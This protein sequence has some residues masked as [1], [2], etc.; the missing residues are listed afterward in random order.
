MFH[1]AKDKEQNKNPLYLYK[2]L[3]ENDP[4][5]FPFY[6]IA[7]LSLVLMVLVAL[8]GRGQ[9]FLGIIIWDNSDTFMDYFNSV[10]DVITRTPYE[11]G[12]IYPPLANLVY[13]IFGHLSS[14]SS[15]CLVPDV[16]T[17][18]EMR[19]YQDYMLPFILY[20]MLTVFGVLVCCMAMKRGSERERLAFTFLILFSAPMI[21]GFERANI[22]V[23]ALIFTMIFF[24]WKDS[25]NKVLR[26]IAL[27]S[28]AMAAALKIYPAIFG[29]LVLRE[30]RFKETSRLI[31]YGLFFLFVPFVFF[32]GFDHITMWIH[33]ISQMSS[34]VAE[35]YYSYKLNFSNTF[36]WL[37]NGAFPGLASTIFTLTALFFGIAGCFL[38]RE[39][40]KRILMATLLLIGVPQI[41]YIYVAI[42]MVIPLIYFLNNRPVI[43]KVNYFYLL[44]MTATMVLIPFSGWRYLGDRIH[45]QVAINLSTAVESAAILVMTITLLAEVV[46]LI[47]VKIRRR[48]K[49]EKQNRGE[50]EI[51]TIEIQ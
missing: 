20:S 10:R 38:L 36:G 23:V 34:E 18:Y 14:V 4:F 16:I 51:G 29:L 30:K 26:E 25:S 2:K 32:G 13:L 47:F 49:K 15:M 42:F 33:N 7:C 48:L 17:S 28:L 41:S 45:Y 43:N 3:K 40:W 12:V 37:T 44:M 19:M 31:T 6:S 46:G 9:S 1:G 24:L 21:Y 5:K 8:Y 11:I 50:A 35:N 22:I 27:I 39:E